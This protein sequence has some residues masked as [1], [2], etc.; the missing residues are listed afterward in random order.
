MI[1]AIL[2]GVLFD[3]YEFWERNCEIPETSQELFLLGKHAF[4][5]DLDITHHAVMKPAAECDTTESFQ[6]VR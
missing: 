5:L 4:K 3:R 1:E 6:E 2:K